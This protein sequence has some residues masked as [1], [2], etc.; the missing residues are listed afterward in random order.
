M[1]EVTLVDIAVKRVYRK[2]KQQS[3]NHVWTKCATFAENALFPQPLG[4]NIINGSDDGVITY[5]F[6]K[7]FICI[8]GK[9]FI[10]RKGAKRTLTA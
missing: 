8:S 7:K 4:P 5:L 2:M 9:W 10:E 1:S 3:G 6:E